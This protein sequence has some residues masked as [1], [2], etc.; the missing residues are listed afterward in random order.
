MTNL[1]FEPPFVGIRGNVQTSSIARWKVRGPG[2]G[3]SPKFL[4]SPLIFLQR[5]RLATANLVHSLG[6]PRPIIK[7]HPDKKVGW[8]WTKEVPQNFGFPYNISA[9][10]GACDFKFGTQLGF[11]KAHD[12]ITRIRKGRHFPGLG[13]LPK[14]CGF[15]SIF[16]Q[17]LKLATSNLVYTFGLPRPIIKS[18][19]EEKWG[20][21]WVRGAPQM[22]GVPYNISATAGL[23]TS[24]LVHSLGF[25]R[26]V[27]K[28]HPDKKWGW[29]FSRRAPKYL[30]F[31]FNISA[32]AT[33]SS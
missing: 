21:P 9:T 3:S 17:W 33:L 6:L 19:P 7:S 25:P 10:A 1:L 24:N 18:H 23:G 26:P 29:S 22:F 12:K 32:T 13:E 8:P 31:P 11:A 4:A 2:L 14:I 15:L 28:S 20:R 16:T 30:G 5:L 27:I